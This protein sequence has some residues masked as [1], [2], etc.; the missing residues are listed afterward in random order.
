M[1]DLSS[2][3]SSSSRSISDSLTKCGNGFRFL[4]AVT[5]SIG[6]THHREIIRFCKDFDERLYY[7]R[8]C[9]K[10]MWS[11][12]QLLQHL[13]ADDY[14][15]VGAL[16]NN[17]E[18]TLSPM[19][20]AT[21]AV[22]SF[23]DE[24]LLELVNLDNVDARVDQDVDERVLSKTLVADVEKTI[25]ALGGDD[26][27]FMGREKR[28]V[29]EDEEFF[30]DLLFYHRGLRALVAVE[31]KMGKFRPA[32]LGQL[33]FYL[34]ALDKLVK[35][36]DE[37][38]SIGLLLCEE[39]KKPVVQLAVQ[40]VSKPIGVAT[41]KT[42]KSILQPSPA[43]EPPHA[44]IVAERDMAAPSA[45]ISQADSVAVAVADSSLITQL[46][47][48]TTHLA[49]DLPS[50]NCAPPAAPSSMPDFKMMRPADVKRQRKRFQLHLAYGGAPAASATTVDNFLSVI[51]FATGGTQR[52]VRLYNWEDYANYLKANAAYMDTVES[53]FMHQ[54]IEQH[55][56][57]MSGDISDKDEKI[58]YDNTPL[59]EVKHH[60]RPR[61]YMLSLSYPLNARWSLVS[62]LG[63]TTMRS[64]FESGDNG[65]H[66]ARRTQRLYY[67]TVPLGASYNI[68]THKRWSLYATGSLRLDL[69]LRGRETTRFVYTGTVEHALGDS[70]VFPTT[71]APVRAPWQWSVG[72]GLGV[73]YR[74][75][76]HVNAFFEPS[77]RYYIPT[78][79]PVENYRTD[80]PWDIALPFGLRFTP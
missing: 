6:F 23:R 3:V 52:S 65:N 25:Q 79:S 27:C 12:E 60:E 53:K 55:T 43:T 2:L 73:Q 67:L 68:W 7:I 17:F 26:F 5:F 16:P 63:L 59:S 11:V 57:T 71:H 62:G 30:I 48:A 10:G 42:L 80:H 21:R 31:L 61:T 77:F 35:R 38:Q 78:H 33:N 54:T 28:L 4:G 49:L 76:P 74:L 8:E 20:Q 40:D 32:Y 46:L 29:F 36:A 64:T 34:S 39:M 14:H 69:P 56:D 9:A 13:R 75:L 47:S 50:W 24:Y 45:V 1:K 66:I 72:A 37:N 44:P 22:R 58:I 70:L 19:A 41:Y 51:N 15:H 18:K